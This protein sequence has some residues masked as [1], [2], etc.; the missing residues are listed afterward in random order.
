MIPL[1]GGSLPKPVGGSGALGSMAMTAFKSGSKT[2]GDGDEGGKKKLLDDKE[3][4]PIVKAEREFFEVIKKVSYAELLRQVFLNFILGLFSKVTLE[5]F[6]DFWEVF[7]GT[8]QILPETLYF[9]LNLGE[10]KILGSQ[11]LCL[12]LLWRFEKPDSAWPSKILWLIMKNDQIK[13]SS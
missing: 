13:L 2:A 3:E 6:S 10:L 11:L 8:V 4:D 7:F 12:S 5:V 1:L 9:W